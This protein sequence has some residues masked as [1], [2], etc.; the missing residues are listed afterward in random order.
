MAICFVCPNARYSHPAI[1]TT[2]NIHTHTCFLHIIAD[3]TYKYTARSLMCTA[4]HHPAHALPGD[5]PHSARYMREGCTVQV[6]TN[7]AVK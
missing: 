5:Q 1:H 4:R 6:H 3:G 7:A 2:Y